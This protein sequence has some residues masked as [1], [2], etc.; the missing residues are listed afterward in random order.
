MPLHD[1]SDF[2]PELADLETPPLLFRRSSAPLKLPTFHC[3]PSLTGLELSSLKMGVSSATPPDPKVRVQSLPTT[4]RIKENKPIKSYSKAPGVFSSCH[5]KTASLPLLDVH[6][7]PRWDSYP[8]VT[9]FVRDPIYGPRNFATL[10]T[11]HHISLYGLDY[12]IPHLY[13]GVRRVVSEDS[14][15][16]TYTLHYAC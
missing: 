15:V 4:L 16:H 1:R 6:R 2:H 7:A 11:M 9:P 13:L 12:I 5:R 8:V 10:G 14:Q 3:L